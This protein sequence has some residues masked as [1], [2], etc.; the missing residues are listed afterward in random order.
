MTYETI[1]LENKGGIGKLTFNRPDVL[2]AYNRVLAVEIMEGFKE[3]I[4]D[5]SVKYLVGQ[6]TSATVWPY[7]KIWASI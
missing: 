6:L 3:L 2:N 7:H 4:D 1:L 5:A